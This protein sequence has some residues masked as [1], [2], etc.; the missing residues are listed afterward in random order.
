VTISGWAQED[1]RPSHHSIPLNEAA[2]MDRKRTSF[3]RKITPEVGRGLEKL[4]HA[5]EYLTDEFVHDGCR[6]AEDRARL[7]AIELLA[8]LKR[9]IYGSCGIEPTLRQ[10]VQG[11]FRK[12]LGQSNLRN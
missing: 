9:Q 10:R 2:A 5:V 1:R 3:R 6:F 8:S 7:H 4:G 12:L 11:L